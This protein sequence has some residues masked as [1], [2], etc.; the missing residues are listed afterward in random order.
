VVGCR[1]TIRFGDPLWLDDD[2]SAT[3]DDDDATTDDDD[4]TTDDDDA[5]TDDDDA[6]APGGPVVCGPDG[7]E[8]P[9]NP[10]GPQ[11]RTTGSAAVSFDHARG[12][13]FSA[14]WTGCE[15][16]HFFSTDGDYVCGVRWTVAGQS[17]GETVQQTR[18]VSRFTMDWSID[19]NTC[20]PNDPAAFR[21]DD[22]Y[23]LIVPYEQGTL[24]V[25]IS[26][27][28]SATP[29]QMDEWASLPWDGEGEEEPDDISFEYLTAFT[30]GS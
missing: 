5:T 9:V 1:G 19:E 26:D 27:N 21:A 18:L 8:P 4:A 15:A 20:A 17:Y 29:A 11:S 23:R 7:T 2:D 24:E 28:Q 3:T 22:Y 25:W 6:T 10:S 30:T 14:T 16:R 12:G 13:S